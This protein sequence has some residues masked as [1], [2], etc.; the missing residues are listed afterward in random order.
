MGRHRD[1]IPR[2][3]WP[4]TFVKRESSRFSE[5]C[6]HKKNGGKVLDSSQF[7]YLP[8]VHKHMYE[9]ILAREKKNK[10]SCLKNIG[11]GISLSLEKCASSERKSPWDIH[12][13]FLVKVLEY[14]RTKE[15]WPYTLLLKSCLYQ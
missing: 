8:H 9:H 7:L 10:Y 1:S 15:L 14:I 3:C 5:R 4:A 2:V 6:Y 12:K 13:S 11:I